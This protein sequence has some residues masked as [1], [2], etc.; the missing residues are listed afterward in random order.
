MQSLQR[1]CLASALHSEEAPVK[2]KSQDVD[3]GAFRLDKQKI[4]IRK[5]LR[6]DRWRRVAT[7][8]REMVPTS[9]SSAE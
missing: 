4:E 5:D 7:N 9:S 6:G 8:P 3:R 2:T 1:A